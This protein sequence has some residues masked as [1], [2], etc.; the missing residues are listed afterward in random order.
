MNKKIFLVLFVFLLM[1]PAAQA[2]IKIVPDCATTGDCKTCDF[3]AL[4][5]NLTEIIGIA[6]GTTAVVMLIIGGLMWILGGANENMIDKGKKLV[7]GTFTGLLITFFAWTLV[8]FLIFALAGGSLGSVR[9]FSQEWWNPDCSTPA[10]TTTKGCEGKL[11][12]D[13]CNDAYSYCYN[14]SAVGPG[15]NCSGDCTC[16]NECTYNL[17][18]LAGEAKSCVDNDD[19]CASDY[20]A[21]YGD[22]SCGQGQRC[23]IKLPE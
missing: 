4:A 18:V 20:P 13:P 16:E 15:E 17:W 5:I 7:V 2:Q 14:E 9:I 22:D 21:T 11:V 6:A 8:N 10:A 1:A 3:L 12:G 19:S 23:C